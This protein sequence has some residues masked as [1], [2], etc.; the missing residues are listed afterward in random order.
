MSTDVVYKRFT[1]HSVITF[2]VQLH[3]FKVNDTRAHEAFLKVQEDRVKSGIPSPMISNGW[4]R[5]L[6]SKTAWVGSNAI[7]NA[8]PEALYMEKGFHISGYRTAMQG[9]RLLNTLL[10]LFLIWPHMKAIE[11][12]T[13][14]LRSLW[15][16]SKQRICFIHGFAYGYSDCCVPVHSPHTCRFHLTIGDTILNNSEIFNPYVFSIRDRVKV[17]EP[18]KVLPNSCQSISRFR[19]PK[20]PT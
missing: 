8:F 19:R 5:R 18:W 16:L 11:V 6:W 4:R 14:D 20:V 7:Q 9:G 12:T 15:N 1:D 10:V 17:F 13:S 3:G 2:P